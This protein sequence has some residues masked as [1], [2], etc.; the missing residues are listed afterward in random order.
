MHSHRFAPSVLRKHVAVLVVG[1]FAALT[2]VAL[3]SGG[4]QAVSARTKP[5][6]VTICHR[7]HATTNPYRM[8]TVSTNSVDGDLHTPSVGSESQGG[9]GDHAG[10]VHNK[11]T[12]GTGQNPDVHTAPSVSDLFD[13]GYSYVSNQKIWEDIIPPFITV[14]GNTTLQYPGMNWTAIGKAIYYGQSLNGV[15]YSGLCGKTG[16]KEFGDLEYNSWLLDNPNA[17]PT[18]KATKKAEIVTDLKEQESLEDKEANGGQAFTGNENFDNLPSTPAK[19]KGPNKPNP[20]TTLQTNL[21]SHNNPSNNPTVIKQALAGVVWKDMNQ[22]GVQD[23]GELP[24]TSVAITVKDPVTGKEL[25]SSDLGLTSGTDYS[26]TSYQTSISDSQVFNFANFFGGAQFRTVVNTVTVTTD[27]NG[28]FQVPYLPDGEWQVVVTTPT[29]WSYTYDSTGV[30]DGD[31][32]GTI[33]PVG[34]VGFAWAG[35][36][37]TGSGTVNADGSI[38]NA[39]GSITNA[40]GSITPALANTGLNGQW[41]IAG[42]I[43]IELI[44]TGAILML[45][46]RRSAA[47]QRP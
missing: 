39:D 44:V 38:T 29:G 35:L 4:A 19:P 40:D 7:T 20:L 27:A 32:P 47:K 18:D 25:T 31:M 26:L 10:Y 2:L 13:P 37:Y 15:D 46:R 11:V 3:P 28:Y 43:G 42:V 36:V 12:Q 14:R 45:L 16:A 30:S 5:D 24:F 21:D 22:N 17:T 33:V 23:N 41:Y 6:K 8:I 9:A 34:G 1:L